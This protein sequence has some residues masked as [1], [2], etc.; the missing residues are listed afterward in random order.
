MTDLGDN[1]S[2]SWIR[3]VHIPTSRTDTTTQ[4]NAPSGYASRSKG[5]SETVN[6]AI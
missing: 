2:D 1:R 6:A 3:D 4:T 5:R